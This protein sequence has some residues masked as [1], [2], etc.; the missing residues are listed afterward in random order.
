MVGRAFRS[1][2]KER[3]KKNLLV[4]LTPTILRDDDFQKSEGGKK[5]MQSSAT[6]L[7]EWD[8][9]NALESTKPHDWRKP[10]Y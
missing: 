2:S 3:T 4:F 1:N 9:A 10:V 7:S 8:E 6:G 5:F